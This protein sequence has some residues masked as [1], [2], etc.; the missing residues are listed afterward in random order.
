MTTVENMGALNLRL[1]YSQAH[2]I[3]IRI[4]TFPLGIDVASA[5]SIQ[6]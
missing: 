3:A 1:R 6:R 5:G 2:G 4:Y